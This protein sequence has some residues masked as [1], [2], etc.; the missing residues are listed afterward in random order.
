MGER[1][2]RLETEDQV[3]MRQ[4]IAHKKYAR[5]SGRKLAKIP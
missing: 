3:R 5:D 2:E 1:R 4:Y